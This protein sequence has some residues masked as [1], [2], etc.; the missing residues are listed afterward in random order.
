MRELDPEVLAAVDD[1]DRSLVRAHLALSPL[2]RREAAFARREGLRRVRRVP[3][4]R[5][6]AGAA[7]RAVRSR[8]RVRG[9]WRFGAANGGRATLGQALA[10]V[11][12]GRA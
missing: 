4:R 10:P 8:R 2:E 3:A 9:G 12:L 6:R 1:V 5:E 7:A 11:E